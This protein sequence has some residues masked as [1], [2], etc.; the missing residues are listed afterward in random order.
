MNIARF[1]WV[2]TQVIWISLIIGLLEQESLSSSFRIYPSMAGRGDPW[3]VI[4][5]SRLQIMMALHHGESISQIAERLNVSSDKIYQEIRPLLEY[6]LLKI[7]DQRIV[8]NIFI[9]DQKEAE[10]TYDFARI[11]GQR[12]AQVIIQDWIGIENTFY[13]LSIGRSCSLKKM[14]F[15]LIGSRI[16]DIGVLG[17]LV[18]DQTL[19]HPAPS[20]P[21]PLQ[22]DARYYFWIVEGNDTHLGKYGQDDT[23]L[24][25]PGWHVLNFGQSKI[26]G[27]TNRKRKELE[28]KITSIAQSD[29]ISSPQKLAEYLKIPCLNKEESEIWELICSQQ[30]RMLLM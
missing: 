5:L 19:L 6:H 11:I 29:Q 3:P 2:I 16:I 12:L 15:M 22:P 14:G 9:A 7:Q 1:N 24:R 26:D 21:C 20:R 18:R 23:Q 4:T 27:K 17:A 25:W 30:S 13:R 8:P 10:L 28:K